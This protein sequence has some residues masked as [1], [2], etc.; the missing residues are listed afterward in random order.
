MTPGK[1]K[2][3]TFTRLPPTRCPDQHPARHLSLLYV[4]TLDS[5]NMMFVCLTLYLGKDSLFSEG[6][7]AHI[8]PLLKVCPL[9]ALSSVAHIGPPPKVTLGGVSPG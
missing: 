7:I 5:S 1:Q 6:S 9:T 4:H 2:G 3:Y 8:F